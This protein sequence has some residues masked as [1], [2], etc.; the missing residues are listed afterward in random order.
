MG[1]SVSGS[2]A[3][4]FTAMFIAFGMFHA[5]TTNGFEEVSDAQEDR[6]DRDLERQNTAINVTSATWDSDELTVEVTNNGSTA[7]EIEHVD[8]LADNEY[9]TGYTTSI[10]SDTT[11]ETD[12]ATDLL[13]PGE[14]L[15]IT[16]TVTPEPNRVKIVT[17]PG[18]A[19]TEVVV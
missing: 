16:A 3:I 19:G 1:F 8:L 18:V 13:L 4:I 17:G 5:A 2:A 9:L 15:T 6:T 7:L 12:T 10:S 14:E 11:T